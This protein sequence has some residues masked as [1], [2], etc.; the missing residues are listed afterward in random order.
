MLFNRK[1]GE[2]ESCLQKS[3]L[4]VD[5]RAA[6]TRRVESRHDDMLKL[7]QT[8]T[9]AA[10]LASALSGRLSCLLIYATPTDNIGR[11]LIKTTKIHAVSESDVV[12]YVQCR[13]ESCL[14]LESC[15][16]R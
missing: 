3:M 11:S 16:S 12:V 4:R 15:L 9:L 8:V 2:I 14:P 13:H 5:R 7:P 6:G 10:S 1:K